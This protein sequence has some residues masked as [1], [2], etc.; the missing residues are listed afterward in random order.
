MIGLEANRPL[1]L[2]PLFPAPAV[3]C[4][5]CAQVQQ[6]EVH[7]TSVGD[8]SLSSSRPR[9]PCF[10]PLPVP[11]HTLPLSPAASAPSHNLKTTEQKRVCLAHCFEPAV[12]MF[13]AQNHKRSAE[14]AACLLPCAL[15]STVSRNPLFAPVVVVALAV[16]CLGWYPR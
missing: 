8:S 14:K 12:T 1:E 7:A 16:E 3:C 5:C 15:V 13:Q 6:Q 11:S 9:P 10:P 2:Q 4:R